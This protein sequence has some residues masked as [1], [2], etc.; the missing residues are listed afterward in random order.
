MGWKGHG[1]SLWPAGVP[2]GRWVTKGHKHRKEKVNRTSES[3]LIASWS[4]T[5]TGAVALLP[6]NFGKPNLPILASDVYCVGDE[7]K[8]TECSMTVH[9]L[10]DGRNLLGQ[11]NVVGVSCQNPSTCVAPP[12]GGNDCLAGDIQLI[13]GGSS[14]L[15]S[16]SATSQGT[17]QYCYKGLW[18]PMCSISERAATVACKQMGFTNYFCKSNSTSQI[19]CC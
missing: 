11:V 8:L 15:Q 13:A 14:T 2:Q 16:N 17:L 3:Y 6:S 18:S 19:V 7:S 9:S 10:D 12:S 1:S 5:W 4:S